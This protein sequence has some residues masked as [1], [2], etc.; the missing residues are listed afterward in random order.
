M[1]KLT[2]V[3]E[4]TKRAFCGNL[5][6]GLCR[7]YFAEHGFDLRAIKSGDTIPKLTDKGE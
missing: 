7:D 4:T 2:T 1:T 3:A 5:A 6:C